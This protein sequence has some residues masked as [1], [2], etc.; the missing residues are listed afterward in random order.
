M[1]LRSLEISALEYLSKALKTEVTRDSKVLPSI[2]KHFLGE[3]QTTFGVVIR[4]SRD[5][6]EA[7]KY[8]RSWEVNVKYCFLYLK[9]YNIQVG[10]KPIIFDVRG[11]KWITISNKIAHLRCVRLAESVVSKSSIKWT[12]MDNVP[13]LKKKPSCVDRSC[14]KNRT[15][16]REVKA[17]LRCW[18]HFSG[19]TMRIEAGC[20]VLTETSVL[21][22]IWTTTASRVAKRILTLLDIASS[23][24]EQGSRKTDRLRTLDGIVTC[25]WLCYCQT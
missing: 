6:H 14:V 8:R 21:A 18:S 15:R 2:L 24:A 22:H 13:K 25:K 16:R 4:R 19:A 7:P 5:V 23:H 10:L 11:G 3:P 1:K 12:D 17:D 20:G 9:R